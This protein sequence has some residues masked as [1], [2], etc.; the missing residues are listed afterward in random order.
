MWLHSVQRYSQRLD[1]TRSTR[2]SVRAC[3]TWF[4]SDIDVASYYPEAEH[5]ARLKLLT[6]SDFVYFDIFP[7]FCLCYDDGKVGFAVYLFNLRLLCLS[8]S[9]LFS[10]LVVR[11]TSGVL[12]CSVLK[13]SWGLYA[14][15]V[16]DFLPGPICSVQLVAT[17][18]YR[19]WWV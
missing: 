11:C 3:L 15:A 14:I 6:C 1:S 8:L 4:C 18:I 13:I 16:S 10:N 12:R 19:F 2:L 9:L 17:S 5:H 7:Y